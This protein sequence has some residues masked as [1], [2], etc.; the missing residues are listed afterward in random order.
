MANLFGT[1]NRAVTRHSENGAPIL[2]AKDFL[3]SPKGRATLEKASAFAKRLN[4]ESVGELPK[5]SSG[6]N[7]G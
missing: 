1:R 3:D 6:S 2:E 7:E 4:L 5:S